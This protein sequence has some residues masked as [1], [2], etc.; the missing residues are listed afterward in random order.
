MLNQPRT[1]KW[2][3]VGGIRFNLDGNRIGHEWQ[4]LIRWSLHGQFFSLTALLL[5]PSRYAVAGDEV[6]R[7]ANVAMTA[8]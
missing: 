6:Q 7:K 4:P 8:T 3:G 5:L 2:C 1:W